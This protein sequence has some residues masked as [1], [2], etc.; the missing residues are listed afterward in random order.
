[1]NV[2]TVVKATNETD[3]PGE[4][5]KLQLWNTWEKNNLLE[6]EMEVQI[7]ILI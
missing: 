7:R 2:Y 4:T 5:N 1:M 3:Y 6:D